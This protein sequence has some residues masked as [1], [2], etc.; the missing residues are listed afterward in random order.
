MHWP[1][2]SANSALK[3]AHSMMLIRSMM[4]MKA[5]RKLA[6]GPSSYHRGLLEDLVANRQVP[7]SDKC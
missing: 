1:G 4:A 7:T 5:I 3:T 6:G 2:L